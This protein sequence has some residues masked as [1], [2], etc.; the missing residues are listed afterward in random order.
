MVQVFDWSD[1]RFN[2]TIIGDRQKS[3]I[4]WL[5]GFMGN[6]Q[7]FLPVINHLSEFCC[8]VVD[9]PGHGQTKVGQD[10]NYQM[11][12]TALALISLLEA[13]AI[14]QCWLVGYSL[15]GRIALYLTVF[16]P[17]YFQAVILESASPGLDTQPERD[18]RI[19]RDL[20]L[21]KQLESMDLAQFLRQWYANP[22]FFSFVQHPHYQQ[23]IAIR[24]QNDPLKLAKSLRLIGLGMQPSLWSYLSE[25]QIPILLIVG[26]LDTKFIAINQQI[27]SLCPQASLKVVQNSGH[28]I[29]FEQPAK[30]VNLI[31]HF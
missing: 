2:Y 4:L 26:A 9:L 16:F 28:N 24:L 30:F 15:G 31:K 19:E 5:H 23:A 6:C 21:A 3:I 7:E 27:A 29:H 10:A 14:K 25:I 13:L 12:N 1:Y 17:Q 20:K 11:S 18:R 22:L 8:L